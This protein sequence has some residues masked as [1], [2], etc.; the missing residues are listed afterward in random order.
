MLE[1]RQFCNSF[2]RCFLFSKYKSN[3]REDKRNEEAVS[4]RSTGEKYGSG[5]RNAGG[6]L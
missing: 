1:K 6:D 3:G 4:T 5:G 2:G